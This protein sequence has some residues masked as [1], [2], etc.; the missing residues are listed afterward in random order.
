MFVKSSCLWLLVAALGASS[1]PLSGPTSQPV[2]VGTSPADISTFIDDF[3]NQWKSSH[4]DLDSAELQRV[5]VSAE[6]AK[7]SLLSTTSGELEERSPLKRDLHPTSPAPPVPPFVPRHRRQLQTAGNST[8]GISGANSTVLEARSLVRK[9][10]QEASARNKERFANPRTNAYWAKHGSGAAGLR[11][12]ADDLAAFAINETIA[13]AAAIVA[14]ADYAHNVPVEYPPLPDDIRQLKEQMFGPA[15]ADAGASAAAGSLGKRALSTF[16]M[17]DISHTGKVPFGGSANDGYKVFRNVKDYGAKGDGKTDDTEAINRAMSD[18]N[19][20]GNNCGASTVKPAIVYFPSGTYLVSTPIIAY[21]NTQIIGNAN[22]RPIIKAAKSFTGLGVISVDEYTGGNGGAE[23]WYINQNNFLRQL[24]NFIVDV[25]DAD[26]DDVAGLHWQVA[27]ATSIQ[28][29]DFY[30]SPS[31]DKHHMGIFAENGSGGFMGDMTFFNGEIGIRCGNQQFTSINMVFVGCRTGIDMLWDWGWT[32]KGLLMSTAENG[33]RMSGDFRGG[34]IIVM[35]SFLLGMSK[36]ISV[37]TPVGNTP[38]EKFTITLDN[39]EVFGVGKAVDHETDGAQ[40]EGGSRVIRSWVVGKVYD[41]KNPSGTYQSGPLSALHPTEGS[42]MKGGAYYRRQKPQYENLVASDFIN[43][44]TLAKGDG[45]TDDTFA[46]SINLALAAVTRRPLYIP[47]GSYLVKSTLQIPVGSV[48]VGECW[49]QIVANGESYS[50][51]DSPYT[52]VRVGDWGEKG[53]VEIQDLV[54]TTKGPTPGAVLMEW[55]MAED[56]QGSAAMWDSHFRIGGAMGTGL[57]AADCPKLTGTIN[58]KCVAGSMLLHM[59]GSSSGY[60]ENVWA[61]VAD[62]DFDSGPAQTQID[63]YVARGILIESKGGPV[64]LYGTASEHCVFYQYL[65]LGAQDVFMGNIQTESPYY[66]PKPKAPAPFTDQVGLFNGDPDFSECPESEPHCAAAWALMISGSTNVHIFGA[67]LYNWFDDYTQ[68]CIDTQTCQ[69][70][71]VHVEESGQIWFYNLYTIGSANMIDAEGSDPIPAKDN[72][73]TNEHPFTS[74]INAWLLSSSGSGNVDND[75]A[76]QVILGTMLPPC[77]SKYNT[78]ENVEKSKSSI[79]QHCLDKY[80]LQ[81]QLNTLGTALSDYNSILRDGYDDKFKAYQ[82]SVLQQVPDQINKFMEGAQASGN[83]TC[84]E[85][86]TV[87]CCR[88]CQNHAA[89]TNPM[90]DFSTDCKPGTTKKTTTV[91]CPASISNN[92]REQLPVPVETTYTLKNEQ[93]FWEGLMAAYGIPQDWVNI[94]ERLAYFGKGCEGV[95]GDRTSPDTSTECFKKSSVYWHNFPTM[96]PGAA[97]DDPKDSVSKS[98]DTFKNIYD[99]AT[100]SLGFAQWNLYEA[101][102]TDM[103]ATAALPAMLLTDAVDNMRQ[104]A[105]AGEEIIERER[106]QNILFWLNMVL[107]M[108]PAAGQVASSLGRVAIAVALRVVGEAATA[109]LTLY[110]LVDDP[111]NALMTMMGF[112][113]GGGVSRQP[114]REAAAIRR[115]MPKSQFEK[116]P[117]RIRTDLGRIQTVRNVCRARS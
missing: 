87:I 5:L 95:A 106:K 110:E 102:S 44:G 75:L 45:V 109:A 38:S 78:L 3:V 48:I 53:S 50:D 28:N 111:K 11:A 55:N 22:V 61:W 33:I 80:L 60:L 56:L 15:G 2:A 101:S 6:Q 41:E 82:R 35:D 58:P 104:I 37:S 96:K 114:F 20:C 86:R 42:L 8:S 77:P 79:P 91:N 100:V 52:M 66:L 51:A 4:P 12:R 97:M 85:T 99:R 30:Q 81:T 13:V 46:L 107:M 18:Q 59:T 89:C 40:L 27:Q 63:I 64:W 70:H 90:C 103:L 69:K 19:R 47:F 76:D 36:G 72:I 17:E 105:K 54:F 115:G 84:T 112:F 16:W 88:G 74:V 117:P 25:Q 98:Y 32:W 71:L 108:I 65:L 73:N 34:S 49:A 21:Y 26:M 93:G 113:L 67:G 14:E 43:A 29:V 39:V 62:H 57:T 9:A 7:V 92:L 10:Q 24:R 83:W 94:G 23:Q 31:T 116:L 68:D 1:S